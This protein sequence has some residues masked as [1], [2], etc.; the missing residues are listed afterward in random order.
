MYLA[1][2]DDDT[3]QLQALMNLLQQWQQLRGTS[4]RCR[5]FQ[6]AADLLN[7][8]EKEPFSLYLLDVVMP[9]ING[10]SAARS[11]RELDETA[12]IVFLTSTTAFAYESYAVHAADYLLKPVSADKLFAIL[13][14]LYQQRQRP[15]EGLT[16]KCGTTLVRIP[17][18]RLAYVEVRGKHLYFNLTDG[19]I[20]EITGSL[21][22]WEP[23][24]LAEPSF[25]RS[26]RS[27]IVNMLQIAELSSTGIRTF[28]GK[29]LPVSRLIYP[30]LQKEYLKLLFSEREGDLP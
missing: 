12:D 23:L 29:S 15:Q 14:R 4:L 24:L 1:I 8:A 13:D 16:M 3:V 30:Q 9:H 20:R 21:S 28:S 22:E 26:H 25:I 7:E 10:I 6:S 17:F 27:Y 5:T 19:S 11:I 18:S 2:C